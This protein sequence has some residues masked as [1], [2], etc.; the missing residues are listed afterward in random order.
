MAW[1]ACLFFFAIATGAFIYYLVRAIR[2]EDKADT[3]RNICFIVITT[4]GWLI[5]LSQIIFWS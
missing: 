2:L 3:I 5:S 1:Y 4:C